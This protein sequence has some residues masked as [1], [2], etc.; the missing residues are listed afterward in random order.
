MPL[1]DLTVTIA[2]PDRN[3]APIPV[4]L[5][6]LGT[7]GHYTSANLSIPFAGT[8]RIEI[9][10]LVSNVDEAAAAADFKVAS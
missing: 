5:I 1:V 8:W 9:K 6:R 2:N 4:K 10:G 7:G 3:I